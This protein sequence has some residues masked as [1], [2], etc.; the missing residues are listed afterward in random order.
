[1]PKKSKKQRSKYRVI[2]RPAT[3][4]QE[5]LTGQTSP[6]AP[7]VVSQPRFAKKAISSIA[8]QEGQYRYI[9]A[10]LIRIAIIAGAAFLIL[11]IISFIIK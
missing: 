4:G 2:T 8:D 11:I 6:A 10:E 1:M 5:N 3:E 9:G 7:I